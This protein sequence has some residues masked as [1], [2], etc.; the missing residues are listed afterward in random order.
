MYC[1]VIDLDAT[2][3]PSVY[4]HHYNF[5]VLSYY[6]MALPPP[7]TWHSDQNTSDS[8]N[9]HRLEPLSYDPISS[10]TIHQSA[11]NHTI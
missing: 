8:L 11:T 6:A 5:V 10:A 7:Q 1:S 9:L 3:L 2:D 4:N